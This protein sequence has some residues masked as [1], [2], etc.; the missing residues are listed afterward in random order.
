[1]NA[2]PFQPVLAV[3][4]LLAGLPCP[5]YVAGGWAI[6]LYLQQRPRA[7]KDVD[8][9]VFRRDQDTVQQYFLARGW[10]LWKYV[11]N[12]VTLERMAGP[13]QLALPDRGILAQ[14]AT[15]GGPRI[16]LLLSETRDGQWWYHADPRIRHPLPAVGL[17]SALGVPL[18]N[19]AIVLL[20]KARHLYGADP[21][22]LRHR[23]ADARDFRA[24]AGSLTVEQRRWLAGALELLYPDHPWL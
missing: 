22:S 18:L 9:A 5:W 15:A 11:G 17:T 23:A 12:S 21:E 1:M 19:P 24:L 13:Q 14:P 16:D 7:H 2:D 10:E 4:H 20:F 6:D 3:A 8:I